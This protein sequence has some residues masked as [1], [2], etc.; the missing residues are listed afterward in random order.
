MSPTS[1]LAADISPPC[2]AN[3]QVPIVKDRV[4]VPMR[5]PMLW[6]EPLHLDVGNAVTE[7]WGSV[8]VVVWV[9]AIMSSLSSMRDNWE[10]V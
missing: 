4:R 1:P 2:V 9:D 5:M 7:F 6:V 3:H 10:A 8:V